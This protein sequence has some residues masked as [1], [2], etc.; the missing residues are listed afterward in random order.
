MKYITPILFVLFLFGCNSKKE[1]KSTDLNYQVAL[2]FLNSYIENS[3]KM[4][5]AIGIIEWTKMTP[6]ATESLKKELENMVNTALKQDPEIGLD[7]DPFF[8]A[9]DYPDEGVELDDFNAQ[10]GYVTVKGIKWKSF[11]VTIKVVYQNGQ[12]LVDG[13][14]VVNIPVNKRAVR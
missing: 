10:T 3:N 5:D 9:Q 12:T 7:F 2:N 4:K 6:F 8:D 14:G 13:C 1:K 11:K